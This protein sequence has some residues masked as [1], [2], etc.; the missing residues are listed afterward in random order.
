[1]RDIGHG[2]DAE[3]L[4]HVFEPF[5][6][7]K[8]RGKGTGLGLASVYGIVKQTAVSFRS[9]ASRA[10]APLWCLTCP[11]RTASQQSRRISPSRMPNMATG[12]VVLVEDNAEVRYVVRGLVE[13][14]CSSVL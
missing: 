9:L 1:M 6:A 8:P 5:F 4:E 2:I 12:F 14:L 7:T 10:R 3:A 11:A 13:R